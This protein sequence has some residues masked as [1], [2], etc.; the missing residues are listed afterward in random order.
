MPKIPE[1]ITTP[2]PVI[3]TKI[4]E[5]SVTIPHKDVEIMMDHS[6]KSKKVCC[7]DGCEDKKQCIV[8]NGKKYRL[9]P[10]DDNGCSI[11]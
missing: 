9:V 2:K 10:D 6:E 4:I 7:T 8:I 11:F 3:K 1:K 5:I